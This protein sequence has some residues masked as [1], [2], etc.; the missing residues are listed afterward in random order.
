M[1]SPSDGFQP[2]IDFFIAALTITAGF[3]DL[4]YRLIIQIPP[5]E[6]FYLSKDLQRDNDLFGVALVIYNLSLMD[7]HG[8]SPAIIGSESREKYF[9]NQEDIVII[10]RL[11]HLF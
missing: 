11:S 1:F 6:F 7:T 5:Q 4:V 9:L 2:Y 8:N 3:T 10:E